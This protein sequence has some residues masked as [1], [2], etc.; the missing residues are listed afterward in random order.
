MGLDTVTTL[1]VAG[2]VFCVL[3]ALMFW[4][5]KQS[6]GTSGQGHLPFGHEIRK[7]KNYTIVGQLR[8]DGQVGESSFSCPSQVVAHKSGYVQNRPH[9]SQL[10]QTIDL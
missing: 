9:Q 2:S 5:K 6:P 10:A 4:A 1:I 8:N 7:N 3:F